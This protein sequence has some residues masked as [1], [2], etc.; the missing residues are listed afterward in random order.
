MKKLFTIAAMLCV[1]GMVQ[2][3]S[4]SWGGA[5]S[6]GDG[7]TPIAAGSMA[8]LIY[9]ATDIFGGALT[10]FD[11]T[12]GLTNLGG[13]SLATHTITANEAS[14]AWGFSDTFIRA[15]ASG[16][17]NGYWQIVLIDAADPT[18]FD[19]WAAPQVTGASDSTGAAVV[20][21]NADWTGSTWLGDGFQPTV[22][23]EPTSMA[24]LALGVAA[25]GLRRKNRK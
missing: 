16:G 8:Y 24:L 9:S 21:L 19:A 1:A 17:V 5:I 13:Q 20:K 3:A 12:T 14:V 10:T 2:A 11:T 6:K 22:V 4:V 18:R 23:P 25:L 7:V 15:D